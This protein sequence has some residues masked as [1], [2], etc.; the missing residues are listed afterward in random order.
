ML[1]EVQVM[2]RPLPRGPSR[3]ASFALRKLAPRTTRH[4]RP[5]RYARVSFFR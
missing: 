4:V 2:H 1:V 5:R 3:G